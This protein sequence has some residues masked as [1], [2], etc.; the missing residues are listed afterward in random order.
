[1][2]KF[3]KVLL[4]VSLVLNVELAVWT[5]ADIEIVEIFCDDDDADEKPVD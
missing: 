2:G 5:L 4:G 3:G 1:M